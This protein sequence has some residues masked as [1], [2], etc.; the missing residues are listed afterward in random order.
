M[1]TIKVDSGSSWVTTASTTDG[2][3]IID[4]SK[5][6]VD[7]SQVPKV[8]K[9]PKDPF[10]CSV[11]DCTQPQCIEAHAKEGVKEGGELAKVAKA[12]KIDLPTGEEWVEKY[13]PKG[14]TII[15]KVTNLR[16]FQA[17]A[18]RFL[19]SLQANGSTGAME[20]KLAPYVEWTTCAACF[21]GAG[22]HHLSREAED[23]R[24]P[25]GHTFAFHAGHNC[26]HCGLDQC[27]PVLTLTGHWV[28]P[29]EGVRVGIID[30]CTCK[31]CSQKPPRLGARTKTKRLRRPTRKPVQGAT[32]NLIATEYGLD[33]ELIL[34]EAAADFYLLVE[35]GAMAPL[36]QEADEI[37]RTVTRRLAEQLCL[38]LE[39]A[40]LGEFRHI[41]GSRRGSWLSEDRRTSALGKECEKF[42]NWVI[43]DWRTRYGNRAA[44]ID[45]R[46]V[47][48]A[49]WKDTR[50]KYGDRIYLL[51]SES[52]RGVS[53]GRDSENSDCGYGGPKWAEC[54]ETAAAYRIG[55]LPSAVF[56]DQAMSLRHN[57]NIAY[58]K[59]FDVSGIGE[60]IKWALE[61]DTENIQ[62]YATAR[63]RELWQ[64]W[65]DGKKGK[66]VSN[67]Q[68]K[69]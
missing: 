58:N 44:P 6:I 45:G 60:V 50:K 36:E 11:E 23:N 18:Q 52:F 67:E 26:N 46:M 22:T 32:M 15:G 21:L 48:W 69:A 2:N 38:Y 49:M 12:P 3:T 64:L 63:V 43:K 30:G 68:A 66:K 10:V 47:A 40:C 41:G 17:R 51:I 31:W 14:S 16:V 62:H 5:W 7:S 13:F 37:F 55:G 42:Q 34:V 4:P 19:V 54:I 20:E 57:G 25:C 8:P 53:W 65:M 24:C 9:P 61:G 1:P 27:Y 29:P 39:L 33:K 59:F 56:V 35:M 28:S